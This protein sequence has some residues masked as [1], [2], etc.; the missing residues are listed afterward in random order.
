MINKKAKERELINKV[1]N[2]K[3]L[4]MG[5]KVEL[6]HDGRM[7]KDTDIV[8]GDKTV[9]TKLAM[10]HLREVPDYYNKLEKAGL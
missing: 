8:R 6:E 7:G 9:L 3:Q 4:S 10:A 1:I 5:K 2:K